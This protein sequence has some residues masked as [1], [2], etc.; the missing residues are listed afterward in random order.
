KVMLSVVNHSDTRQ[1][2][3]LRE[4]TTYRIEDA[5]PAPKSTQVDGVY[6]HRWK[7]SLRAGERC[8]LVYVAKGAHPE[9]SERFVEGLG[10]DMLTGAKVLEGER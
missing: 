5:S 2:F 1:A 9:H 4:L 10:D 7:L 6:E 3:V 8:E